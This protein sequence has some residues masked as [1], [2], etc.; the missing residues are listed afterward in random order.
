MLDIRPLTL[1]FRILLS[2][3][4]LIIAIRIGTA[5][6]PLM[7]AVSNNALIGSILEKFIQSPIT[8]DAAITCLCLD[9]RFSYQIERNYRRRNKGTVRDIEQ[10]GI[11]TSVFVPPQ[12]KLSSDSIEVFEKLGFSL[13]EMQEKFFLLSHKP[14]K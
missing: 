13:T 2:L 7:T 3:A 12:W 5:T 6:T 1:A 14:F 8:V 10:V 11:K 4:I 9:G